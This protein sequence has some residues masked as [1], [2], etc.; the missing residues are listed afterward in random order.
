MRSPRTALLA[1]AAVASPG[2]LRAQSLD[3]ATVRAPRIPGDDPVETLSASSSH[4]VA[5]RGRLASS[6]GALLEDA[7]G[8]HVRHAGADLS[9]ETVVLRG[10]TS[11]HVVVALDGIPLG[12]AASDGVDLAASPP[13][14]LQRIDVYRGVAPLRLG[15]G[16]LAGAIDLR[17]RDV[18]DA[19]VA[20]A[21]AGAGSFGTRRAS[22]GAGAA[23][24][25]VETL[26]AFNYRGTEGNF[27]YYEPGNT[28][29]SRGTVVDRVNDGGDAL[30]G[31]LRVCRR[32]PGGATATCLTV[33]GGWSLRGVAGPG[34]TS[35]V[36]PFLEQRRLLARGTWEWHRDRWRVVVAATGLGRHDL[37]DGRSAVSGVSV[38][39]GRAES[40]T[41]RAQGE[42]RAVRTWRLGTHEGFVRARTEGFVPGAGSTLVDA[43]RVG[44]TAGL[45]STLRLRAVTVAAG[46]VA[47]QLWDHGDAPTQD[48]SLLSP[49]LAV[50]ARATRWLELRVHAGLAQR[51]PTLPERFGDRGV[52]VGNAALRAERSR[53]VDVAAVFSTRAGAWAL[54]A[55]AGAFVRDAS[56]LI[57]LAQVGAGRFRPE[58]FGRV[59]VTGAEASLRLRWREHVTLTVSGTASDAAVLDDGGATGRT[60]PGVPWGDLAASVEGR[61]GGARVGVSLSAVSA[62]WL[63]RSNCTAVPGRATVDARAAW[64]PRWLHGWGALLEVT[65]LGDQRTAT[66]ALCNPLGGVT[67]VTAPIQDFLGYPLPGRAFFGGVTYETP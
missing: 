40:D 8:V 17:L 52:V 56:D 20:W 36:G 16:G 25:G 35:V 61:Y 60:V 9:R 58:N 5:E 46:V 49:R 37:F 6:A 47:E 1:L 33:L 21:A 64:A 22:A 23:Y 11:E 13:A 30:D 45:E 50:H 42:V 28:S 3:G 27:P 14:L 2:M 65:N 32:V 66:Q 26:A 44:I 31:L 63:D 7:P 19:P 59:R 4:D 34:D 57:A 62:A 54:N 15:T 53:F 48:T 55:E 10:A 18:R 24:D 29:A 41:W 43:G 38:G 67:S 12:D 51:A 39:G